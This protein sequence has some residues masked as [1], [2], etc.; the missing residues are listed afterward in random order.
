PLGARSAP[1][2]PLAPLPPAPLPGEV[3]VAV[4]GAHLSGMPLNGELRERNAR[5]LQTTKTAPD[6]RLFALRNTSPRKPGLL[7]VEPGSGPAVEVALWALRHQA[8]GEFVAAIPPPLAIG[9]LSLADG[10][11]VKGF[12]V[13]AEATAGAQDISDLGGWRAF[14]AKA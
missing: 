2:P 9:T 10:R 11:R 12:L 6:Y 7:G 3:V 5:F 8:F 4:V 1:M 14:V 13:E